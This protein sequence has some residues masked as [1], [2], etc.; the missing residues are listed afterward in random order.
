[1]TKVKR[2]IH[3]HVWYE[4]QTASADD[5]IDALRSCIYEM[6]ADCEAEISRTLEDLGAN[7]VET[8]IVVN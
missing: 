2:T 3:L 5:V 4:T 6:Q 8:S 1:M 7:G